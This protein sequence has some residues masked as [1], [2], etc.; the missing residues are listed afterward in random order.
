MT[1]NTATKPATRAALRPLG[2]AR[3]ARVTLEK[4]RCLKLPGAR[5]R[6]ATSRSAA[7][8]N[9]GGGVPTG[10]RLGRALERAAS[11]CVVDLTRQR[12]GW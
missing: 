5:R 8:S 4:R 6:A 7:L 2:S 3:L 9:P 10:S 12:A 1:A 11:P